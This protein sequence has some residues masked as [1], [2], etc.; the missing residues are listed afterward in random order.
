MKG[1]S[2]P[3]NAPSMLGMF[4]KRMIINKAAAITADFKRKPPRGLIVEGV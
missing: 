2:G 3:T 1:Q 4:P